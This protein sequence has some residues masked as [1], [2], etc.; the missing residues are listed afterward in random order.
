MDKIA[1]TEHPLFDRIWQAIKSWDISRA[2]GERYSDATGSD[3]MT[4]IRAIEA[5]EEES[6]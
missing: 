2:P 1:N 5:S 3:V 6:K 4:I